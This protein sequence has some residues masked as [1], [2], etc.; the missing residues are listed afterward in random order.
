MRSNKTA[1]WSRIRCSRIYER[2]W[3]RR[4]AI[5]GWR[6]CRTGRTG[7]LW[8]LVESVSRRTRPLSR[9]FPPLD[10]AGWQRLL[11]TMTPSWMN[12]SLTGTPVYLHRYDIWYPQRCPSSELMLILSQILNYY[13]TGKLHYPTGD[14]TTFCT[15][16]KGSYDT[17]IWVLHRRWIWIPDEDK[18]GMKTN[19]RCLWTSLWGGAWVLGAGQQPGL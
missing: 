10:W 14:Q 12:T 16:G 7:S 4:R 19:F 15:S 17:W 8:T 3:P 9:R 2:S 11:P 18:I 5:A 1:K 13:R 6:W